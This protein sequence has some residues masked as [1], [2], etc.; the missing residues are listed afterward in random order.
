MQN[1][2]TPYICSE[3]I[4]VI[5]NLLPRRRT[6]NNIAVGAD[7]DL[8][9]QLAFGGL[10]SRNVL[11]IRSRPVELLADCRLRIENDDALFELMTHGLDCTK[12][13]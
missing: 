6:A 9:R 7:G 5:E 11:V 3:Q 1:S 2:Y 4:D 13:I 12:L 8:V 10:V